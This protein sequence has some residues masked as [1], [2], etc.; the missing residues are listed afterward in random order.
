MLEYRYMD[1]PPK[2][3]IEN[4][5]SPESEDDERLK[6]YME[7]H[8]EDFPNPDEKKELRECGPEIEEL[9]EMF[10]DF[11]ER[12]SL[13]ELNAI[14]YIDYREASKHPLRGPAWIAFDLIVKKRIVIKKETNIS[15][16]ILKEVDIDMEKI[17]NAV[18][19]I[20]NDGVVDHT[21]GI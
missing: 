6:A 16:E 2:N 12:F 11:K 20:V 21:R 19:Y 18:G 17:S 15:P 14:T 3:K 4:P 5:R 9:K 10:R 7:M 1:K 8:P 13:E